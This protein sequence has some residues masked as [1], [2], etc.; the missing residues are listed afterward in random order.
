MPESQSLKFSANP[1][2]DL[3]YETG[4][5]YF[6]QRAVKSSVAV[7]K[8]EGEGLES[9]CAL[10]GYLSPKTI[11]DIET[12]VGVRYR[13]S[14]KSQQFVPIVTTFTLPPAGNGSYLYIEGSITIQVKWESYTEAPPT[15]IADP[16]NVNL[17]PE[18]IPIEGT[19]ST[20]TPT[21]VLETPAPQTEAEWRELQVVLKDGFNLRH[22]DVTDRDT[23]SH[24]EI[25]SENIIINSCIPDRDHALRI[26]K[27]AIWDSMKN[28][29]YSP[30]IPPIFS[31]IPF[32]LINVYISFYYLTPKTTKF[33]GVSFKNSKESVTFTI[34]TKCS[35]RSGVI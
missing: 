30:S 25:K 21:E 34:E 5:F 22:I 14:I 1:E 33:Y 19:I 2:K 27:K 35:T 4:N 18:V 20:I 11:G 9:S 16:S 7:M 23:I 10:D 29:S 8:I 13:Y 24:R 31:L 12:C 6:G 17:D 26:A 15:I 3:V 28:I 32:M